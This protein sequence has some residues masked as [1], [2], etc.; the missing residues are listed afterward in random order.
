MKKEPTI[1]KRGTRFV[2]NYYDDEGNRCRPSFKSRADAM[3]HKRLIMEKRMGINVG[4]AGVE[5]MT[6]HK[7]P[8]KDAIRKYHDLESAKKEIGAQEK[9]WFTAFYKHFVAKKGY[10]FVD[11]IKLIDLREYQD[12]LTKDELDDNGKLVR[13]ALGNATVNRRF[14]TFKHFFGMV[15]EWYDMGKDVSLKLK[16]LPESPKKRKLWTDEQISQVLEKLSPPFQRQ[17]LFIAETGCRP[18]ESRRLSWGDVDFKHNMLTLWCKKNKSKEMRARKVPMSVGLRLVLD[19]MFNEARRG[20]RAKESDPVF[21]NKH[22]K[23]YYRSSLGRAIQR[24]RDDLGF[25]DISSYGLRHS[26][27]TELCESGH[28]LETLRRLAGHSN[29]RTTQGYLHLNDEASR[30][31]VDELS[32]RRKIKL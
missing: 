17:L 13:P 9:K 1:T 10:E 26:L 19:E 24:V 22:G 6:L 12:L 31:G 21:V 29:I 2:V 27:L 30:L 23:G 28:N 4:P 16:R 20:F 18:I 11:Q 25:G 3:A 14:N 7:A 15:C 8:L 5:L 32:A